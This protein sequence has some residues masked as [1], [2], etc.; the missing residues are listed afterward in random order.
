MALEDRVETPA[1]GRLSPANAE[2]ARVRQD[3][4]PAAE[5]AYRPDGK[6]PFLLAE[7]RMYGEA[8]MQA[9]VDAGAPYI[10]PR[11]PKLKPPSSAAVT[12]AEIVDAVK[13]L[14]DPDDR[15]RYYLGAA[16]G[17]EAEKLDR[18]LAKLLDPDHVLPH[19]RQL[20]PVGITRL[21]DRAHV[22]L[23]PGSQPG[24]L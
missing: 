13:F 3:R 23:N 7:G 6:M 1:Q 20:N 22:F 21:R 8:I 9:I 15:R 5:F 2:F 24:L 12:L 18:M 10:P 17:I 19:S 4:P 14:Y 16:A 11:D